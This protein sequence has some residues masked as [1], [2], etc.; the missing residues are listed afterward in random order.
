MLFI[1]FIVCSP[2]VTWFSSCSSRV[3]SFWHGFHNC[4]SCVMVFDMVFIMCLHVFIVCSLAWFSSSCFM[5]WL[6]I[7]PK[8]HVCFEKTSAPRKQETTL[9]FTRI[10]KN[11]LVLGINL[12]FRLLSKGPAT[13]SHSNNCLDSEINCLSCARWCKDTPYKNGKNTPQKAPFGWVTACVPA[14]F[15]DQHVIWGEKEAASMSRQFARY[16]PSRFQAI[17]PK[18]ASPH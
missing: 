4:S 10:L 14:F 17:H 2:R 18:I 15:W 12:F 7:N 6:W 8:C 3:H 9:T 13:F 5:C 11:I 1:M 16:G